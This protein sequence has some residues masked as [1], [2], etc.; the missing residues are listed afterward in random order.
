M[1]VLARAREELIS[2]SILFSLLFTLGT[3]FGAQM[4]IPLPFTPVPVTLQTFFVLSS[5]VALGP[6][7]GLLSQAIY[8][9]LGI[10]GFPYFAGWSAGM[11][12]L[13]GPTGGYLFGFLIAGYVVGIIA[14]KGGLKRAYM[15][16]CIGNLIIYLLGATW[17][18]VVLSLSP[19]QAFLKGVFPFLPGDTIKILAGGLIANYLSRWTRG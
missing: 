18:G 4:R 3:G 6:A 13:L 15:A 10:V 2:K 11:K 7:W 12:T 9:L 19:S 8:L 17:L 14:R 16:M 5:G 1:K